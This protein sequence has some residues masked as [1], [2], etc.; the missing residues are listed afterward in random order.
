MPGIPFS[1]G[2]QG[3][4]GDTLVSV[5]I[6][7]SSISQSVSLQVAPQH[8]FCCRSPLIVAN[9]EKLA[10]PVTADE[11]DMSLNIGVN[12]IVGIL[13]LN[14]TAARAWPETAATPRINSTVRYNLLI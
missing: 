14:D 7:H 6:F 10:A 8:A 4:F 11:F 13:N 1:F 12:G 9:T 5:T 2:M 3:G